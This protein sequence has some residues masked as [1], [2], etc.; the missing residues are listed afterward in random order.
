MGFIISASWNCCA[1][2]TMCL[3]KGLAKSW[4]GI[5]EVGYFPFI[6]LASLWSLSSALRP[7]GVSAEA[8]SYYLHVNHTDLQMS[9]FVLIPS[10]VC[11]VVGSLK[12]AMVGVFTPWELT[13]VTDQDFFPPWWVS[14]WKLP[15]HQRAWPSYFYLLISLDFQHLIHA[16]MTYFELSL[17]KDRVDR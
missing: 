6:F 1:A 8:G 11:I 10:Q 7:L 9:S 12:L 13:N 3:R 2:V 5:V 4:C 14:C 17:L 16:P 15:A